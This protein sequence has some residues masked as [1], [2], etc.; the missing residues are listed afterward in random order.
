MKETKI[1]KGFTRTVVTV[2]ILY[3]VFSIILGVYYIKEVYVAL[4]NGIDETILVE[5]KNDFMQ[6][7][8]RI[9]YN[10]TAEEFNEDLKKQ[11][12]TEYDKVSFY[13]SEFDQDTYHITYKDVSMDIFEYNYDSVKDKVICMNITYN[14]SR[15]E[16]YFAEFINNVN[17][18]LGVDTNLFISDLKGYNTCNKTKEDGFELYGSTAFS[19]QNGIMYMV[20]TQIHNYGDG[21]DGMLTISIDSSDYDTTD[22][23]KESSDYTHENGYEDLYCKP[24]TEPSDLTVEMFERLI[25]R[26]SNLNESMV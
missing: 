22:E 25:G 10:G 14:N 7:K 20:S 9:V 3:Y 26:L 2:V 1:S 17:N 23:F 4:L 15:V 11:M 12:G 21:E 13:I 18:V 5:N 8:G 6:Y 19:V 16:K 24:N